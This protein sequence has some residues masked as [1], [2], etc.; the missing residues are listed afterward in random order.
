MTYLIEPI[1]GKHRALVF[2]MSW[3]SVIGANPEKQVRQHARKKKAQFYTRGRARSTIVGLLRLHK[4]E[5]KPAKRLDLYSAAAA[6]AR[7]YDRGAVAVCLPVRENCIWVSAAIDG[8]VQTGTDTIHTNSEA[9]AQH[10]EQLRQQHPTLQV[11]GDTTEGKLQ[12]GV[13]LDNLTESVK[14]HRTTIGWLDVPLAFWLVLL[15]GTAFVL[16]QYARAYYLAQQQALVTDTLA[17]PPVDARAAW[18]SALQR[19][20]HAQQMQAT[21][22]LH[23]MLTS[24]SNLPLSPGRWELTEADCQPTQCQ[25]WYRRTRLADNP[26]LRAALPTHWSIQWI[27]MDSA[28]VLV[29]TPAHAGV[30]GQIAAMP[31]EENWQLQVLAHWQR[32]RPAMQDIRIGVKTPVS[33]PAP[34]GQDAAG[35]PVPLPLPAGLQHPTLREVTIQAPLRTLAALTWPEQSQVLQLHVR[36]DDAAGAD[37]AR[38]I[39]HATLKGVIY[40]Q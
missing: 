34:Q 2:G 5:E 16:W 31:T 40:V 21:P 36:R 25:V 27:G 10:L 28:N 33:I 4:N 29:P 23:A 11:L 37:L 35:N 39:F 9:A 15:V 24:L 19:W 3:A 26:S 18:E 22:T 20:A 32:L 30:G 17:P 38:S 13:F 7:A 8:M 14:L 1:A 12:E 6:F